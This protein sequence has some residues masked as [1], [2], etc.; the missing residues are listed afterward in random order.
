MKTFL[1]DFFRGI[2]LYGRAHRVIFRHRLWPLVLLP[3]LLSLLYV[4]LLISLGLI[5]AGDISAY[6]YAHWLPE[7]LKYDWMRFFT[8]LLIWLLILLAGYIS[9]KTVILIICAPILG[10]LSEKVE[11]LLY[12][13]H[14][15]DFQ[16][17]T[18][19]NDLLRSL[20][21][22]LRNLAWSLL[23]TFAAWPF[24]FIP[25]LGEIVFA[26][27]MFQIQSYYSGYGLLDI[28]LERKRYSARESLQ[29]QQRQ[30][31]IVN[32]VGAGF[33]LLMLVPFAGWFLAPSYGAVAGT[34]AA[35]E[36]TSGPILPERENPG[37]IVTE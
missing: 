1:K 28:V 2:A 23:F 27:L 35:L 10:Y 25:V 8:M 18:F 26:L 29:F 37:E 20:A 13:Q 34:L 4:G 19:L 3:G 31:G 9:Y 12:G 30:R 36:K 22:N 32:G 17:K 16:L 21:I 24:L 5:Y 7:M 11:F 15:P 6:I 14:P 33:T